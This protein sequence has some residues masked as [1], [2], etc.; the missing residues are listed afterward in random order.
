[1]ANYTRLT[2]KTSVS[3]IAGS[4]GTPVSV[5]AYRVQDLD[6]NF[7]Q[8]DVTSTNTFIGEYQTATNRPA[9]RFALVPFS[10][11]IV[12]QTATDVPSQIGSLFRGIGFNES[13]A[14]GTYEG[15][16]YQIGDLH[17]LSMTP[18]GDLDPI[19]LK[20]NDDRLGITALNCV[21]NMSM[22]C[23]ASQIP[24]IAWSF[25]GQVDDTVATSTTSAYAETAVPSITAGPNP[26][27]FQDAA[28]FLR[29][30]DADPAATITI[31]SYTF[32]TET[33]LLTGDLTNSFR[34][35]STFV[36]TGSGAANDG[37]YEVVSATYDGSTNTAIVVVTG[38]GA[39]DET[40]VAKYGSLKKN[41]FDGEIETVTLDV[42]LNTHPRP[43]ANAS[44]GFG[45]PIN[46]S[47]DPIFNVQIESNLLAV[48]NPWNNFLA[49]TVYDF[50]FVLDNGGGNGQQIDVTC[51]VKV[52]EMTTI[53]D[54]GEKYD[55]NVVLK[56]AE[57][58]TAT[59]LTFTWQ[60]E[61]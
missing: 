58:E 55:Y 60:S 54:N 26:A 2:R 47:F 42:G 13:K 23:I 4:I 45:Q 15:Y 57:G 29:P 25:R 31:V 9:G 35:R 38:V 59:N 24:I 53:S 56:Q 46:T 19:D 8:A 14:G 10:T 18:A 17:T 11:E 5:A 3:W 1:M 48:H 61:A 52:N 6:S 30:K 7:E 41:F 50:G 21:G 43:D 20:A 28:V 51:R 33:F 49:Q 44:F 12:G 40:G 39:G 34:R 36:I 37:T 27:V 32:A 16:I 22:S